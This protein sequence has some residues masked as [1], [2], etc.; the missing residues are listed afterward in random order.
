MTDSTT[1]DWS[2]R[3]FLRGSS[4]ATAMALLGGRELLAESTPVAQGSRGLACA[5]I[6]LGRW[7]REILGTLTRIPAARLVAVCDSYP[8]SL[9]RG[10][11]LLPEA[12]QV[13]DARRLVGD[14]EIEAIFIATP[15]HLHR[16]LAESALAAGK[17]VYC[18]APLAATLEDA[19]AIARAARHCAPRCVFQAGL[20]ARSDP[21]RRLAAGFYQSGLLGKGVLA[22]AQWHRKNSWRQT[23]PTPERRQEVNWRLDSKRSLG[24]EGEVAIHHLDAASW[25]FG[26]RPVA[27]TGYGS[28][29]HW[30][31]DG[32][33]LPDTVQLLVEFPGGVR[34]AQS[35]TLANSFESEQEL[36]CGTDGS[37]L[38]RS[39]RG[40]LFKEV[41][42]PLYG[43][44]VHARQEVFHDET[45]LVLVADASKHQPQEGVDV[46]ERALSVSPLQ[47]ALEAFLQS[48]LDI[49]A[50]A[51]DFTAAYGTD[52][53][54]SLR[55]H[56]AAVPRRA[57]AG[58]LEGFESTVVALKCRESVS[59]GQMIELKPEDFELS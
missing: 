44:E 11:V 48:A 1:G 33:D 37:V 32:R 6:G 17:H 30:S 58:W 10:A 14:P 56:L 55:N 19:A 9:K 31:D 4:M 3:D 41:D 39:G 42:A 22:R 21:Q 18:E 49:E 28:I 7:G 59:T 29:Q 5:L 47:H 13:D 57:G 50:A 34:L 45:G 20:Q 8:A 38:F 35:C 51:E 27:V 12:R 54:Q 16:E 25:F 40:W 36:F 23:A 26:Q 24:L 53:P 52:D 46:I 43:W 15:T 2:R